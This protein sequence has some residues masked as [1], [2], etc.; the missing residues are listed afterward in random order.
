MVAAKVMLLSGELG[1]GKTTFAQGVGAALGIVRPI[2]SPTFT[3]VNVYDVPENALGVHRLVHADLYRLDTV[4][5]HSWRDLGLEEYA[6]EEGTLLLV[7]WPERL[8]FVVPWPRL[9]FTAQS[10]GEH[11]VQWASR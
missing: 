10:N 3:L 1:S 9:F 6:A 7:E 5:Q 4:D 8:R 2:A 11:S